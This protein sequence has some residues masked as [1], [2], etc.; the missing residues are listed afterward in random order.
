MKLKLIGLAVI[1]SIIAAAVIVPTALAAQDGSSNTAVTGP[2]AFNQDAP[3]GDK[4]GRPGFFE[5]IADLLN[6][7]VDELR[8]RLQGGES[9]LDV[10]GDQGDEVRDLLKERITERINQAAENGRLPQEKADEMLSNLDE[11][12]DDLLNR[13]EWP[14]RG[15]KHRGFGRGGPGGPGFGPGHHGRFGPGGCHGQDADGSQPPAGGQDTTT[16]AEA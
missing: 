1:G 10:A 7:T 13:T 3:E 6:T 14:E 12:I 11:H 9:I 5:A 16:S 8:T 4:A 2:T 15:P